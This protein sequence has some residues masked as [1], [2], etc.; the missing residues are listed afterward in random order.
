[1]VKKKTTK[2][3]LG[4]SLEEIL[5]SKPFEKITISEISEN[6][7]VGRRTFYNN[8]KDKYDLAAWLYL[9]QLEDYVNINDRTGLAEFIRYS[10]E[11]VDKDSQLIIAIDQY[12][13]QNNL[14][15]SLVKP[16]TEIFIKVIERSC[17]R[18]V[19]AELKKDIEFFV[20]GQITFVG[21]AIDT[22]T[23]PSVD[24][25]TELFIRCIPD[26]IKQFL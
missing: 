10:A 2:E 26:S 8:F 13:G 23:A 4:E 18:K 1:M 15:D 6:C 12:K 9:R 19:N 20:G 11:V 16:M 25:V 22:R 7:G 21:R 3:L 5:K 17:G 14:R 24:E